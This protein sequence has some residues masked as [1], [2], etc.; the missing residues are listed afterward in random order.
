MRFPAG[1]ELYF[2][3][4]YR[5]LIPV[6]GFGLVLL[7][8]LHRP[9]HSENQQIVR[10]MMQGRFKASSRGFVP[11]P[12]EPEMEYK[13]NLFRG[14][15]RI[16]IIEYNGRTGLGPGQ[17]YVFLSSPARPRKGTMVEIV[18]TA[19]RAVGLKPNDGPTDPDNPSNNDV[20]TS[21]F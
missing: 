9:K 3:P 12:G 8:A 2:R 4:N 10:A 18:K 21:F 16:G 14:Q 19:V 5:G 6:D 20:G 1:D 17:A 15:Y 13:W 7:V 11:N